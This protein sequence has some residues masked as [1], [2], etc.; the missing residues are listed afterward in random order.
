[1]TEHDIIINT[2]RGDYLFT[3]VTPGYIANRGEA[4]PCSDC[5]QCFR[6]LM[7]DC[8]S[9][10]SHSVI[11]TETVLTELVRKCVLSQHNNYGREIWASI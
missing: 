2:R 9:I 6:F 10:L 7:F 1:M 3:L 11:A 4:H 5:Q 8:F